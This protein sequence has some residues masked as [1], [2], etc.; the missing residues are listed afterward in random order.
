MTINRIAIRAVLYISIIVA[1]SL[2][3]V[4]LAGQGVC[5][6]NLGENIFAAGD[7]GSGTAAVLQTD[8]GIAPGYQYTTNVPPDGSYTICN[9]TGALAGLYPTWLRI[10]DNSSD[11]DGYMMVVNADYQPGIFYQE[12]VEGLCEN[13]L[14]EFSA[15]IINLVLDGTPN[16]IDPNVTFL[17]DDVPVYETGI[18]PKTEKWEKYGFSFITTATQSEITLSLRNNAPGGGGNDLALDNISFRPCGPSSFI[19]LEGEETAIFLCKDDDPLTVVADIDG[20]TGTPYALRWQQSA[21]GNTWTD[22]SGGDGASIT[23]DIFVPGQYYYRYYSAANEINIQNEKCRIISDVIVIT[24]LPDR[25]PA[26]DTICIGSIYTFGTQTLNTSGVYEENFQ[27]QYNCDSIVTLDLVM[28]PSLPIFANVEAT[29]PSCFGLEDGVISID[30]LSGGYGGLAFV[31]GDDEENSVSTNL[32]GGS[33]VATLTDRFG[34]TET[35]DIFLD[36][37]TEIVVDLPADTTVR[38][39]E[40]LEINPSYSHMFV[41]I[42]WQL[43]GEIDC[44][45]CESVSILPYTTH[46]AVVTVMDDRGCEATD[47]MRITVDDG[48]LVHLPNIFSPNDDRINDAFTIHY[49]GRSVSEIE[50]F[51]VYD[52]WGGLIHE[53]KNQTTPSGSTLWDGYKVNQPVAEGIYS[54]SLRVKYINGSIS[55][56]LGTFTV[57]R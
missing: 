6:G 57:V 25:Y 19:G 31:L 21:D 44:D 54:Y 36:Q 37:P 41:D 34:C 7:F 1:S 8:P 17:I 45:N 52:R 9:R 28:V 23:H 18:V 27:S 24:I 46:D 43:N 42:A 11:P 53:I 12:T 35:I 49:F 55:D 5:Q 56:L 51:R 40:A 16:H 20:N 32:G 3:V 30:A 4:Q 50:H 15:D 10:T 22:M 14:Y 2:S 29:D 38:L 26:V 33:Y 39:G 47:S 13:T 48:G